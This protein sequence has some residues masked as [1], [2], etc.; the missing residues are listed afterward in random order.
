MKKLF[1]CLVLFGVCSSSFA[2][3]TQSNWRWR[4]NNGSETSATWKAAQNA[5]ISYSAVSE[6]IRLRLEIYNT[7]S[8]PTAVED[9]LQYSTT[10]A[11]ASSWKNILADDQTRAFVMAGAGSTVAQNTPTTTQ[12]TGNTYVFVPG[13]VMADSTVAKLITIPSSNRTEFEWAIR[14][15]AQTLPNTTYYFRQ[16][17]ASANGLP[18]GVTY[19]SLTTAIAL[20]ITLS[21]F[22][23]GKEGSKVKLEWSTASEENNDRFEVEKSSNSKDWSTIAT[24]KG[25]GSSSQVHN[26]SSYDESP[27]SGVNYYRLKQYDFDGRFNVSE[28]KSLRFDGAPGLIITVSPNPAR[29]MVNFKLNNTI[30]TTIIAV[31]SDANGKVIYKETFRNVQANTN[32]KLNFKQQPTAG[33]YVL[34]LQGEGLSETIKVVMQ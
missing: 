16:W 1:I 33:I 22:S 6:V 18:P 10:P 28:I 24:V 29:G 7:N 27:L 15:T 12:I 25:S 5:P 13:K 32:N 19:P 30:A 3:L 14:G 23:L 26:Y 4:N 17:G 9:S 11:V 2:F 34:K 31:L 21:N 20:P 8:D